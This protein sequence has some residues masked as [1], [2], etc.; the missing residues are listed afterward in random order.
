MFEDVMRKGTGPAHGL[1]D[2][3]DEQF[4]VHALGH[5]RRARP[6]CPPIWKRKDRSAEARRGIMRYEPILHGRGLDVSDEGE[7]S[8]PGLFAAGDPAGNGGCG[9][10]LAAYL[11]WEGGHAAAQ[12]ATVDFSPPR[13]PESI[14][15][16]MELLSR[17]RIA[18]KA[19]TGRT[20]TWPCNR[21]RADYAPPGQPRC[22]PKRFN[23]GRIT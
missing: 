20:R 8:V 5:D 12:A 22:V 3:T 17:S 7:T 11:G 15:K 21:S 1:F 19:R 14:R 10:A 16:R 4:G 9:I 23:A 18:P 2:A 13:K 6:P